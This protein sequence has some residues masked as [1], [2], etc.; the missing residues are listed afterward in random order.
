MSRSVQAIIMTPD[1]DRLLGFYADLFGGTE[2]IRV[3]EEGPTFFVELR[4]G[5]SPLG[6]VSEASADRSAPQRMLL[7]VEVEAVDALLPRVIELG[8]RLRG[9]PTDMPWGQRVA[10][11][12]DPDG[13]AVNLVQPI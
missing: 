11:V 12:E 3:P 4:I 5:D 8:G 7:S 13:N 10:H 9:G 2:H 1:L 6:L